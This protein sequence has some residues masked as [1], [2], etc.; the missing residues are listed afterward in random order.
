MLENILIPEAKLVSKDN[1]V[2]ANIHSIDPSFHVDPDHKTYGP[3]FRHYLLLSHWPSSLGDV[4]P[5]TL[6]YNRYY[7]FLKFI[8]RYVAEHGPDAGLEQ[9]A[10]QMLEQAPT[11]VDW[12][13]IAEIERQIN[14]ETR[15]A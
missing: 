9:Q 1:E 15:S 4:S 8:R 2:K 6:F 3:A 5:E 14:D 13:V 12:S 7:W 10:F 11:D